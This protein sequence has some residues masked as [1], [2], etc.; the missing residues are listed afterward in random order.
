M[1]AGTK[2]G[3]ESRHVGM[4]LQTPEALDGF[5]HA[6]GDPSQHHLPATPALH[7]CASCRTT[8]FRRSLNVAEPRSSL[9][10]PIRCGVPSTKQVNQRAFEFN[11]EGLSY[12]CK[13][14]CPERLQ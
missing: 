9:R 13:N 5:E 7:L 12:R 10:Q 3:D 4:P 14:L 6:C 11:F 2:R 8:R 1:V